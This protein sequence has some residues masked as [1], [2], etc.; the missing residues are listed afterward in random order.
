M[1]FNCEICVF[2]THKKYN[3]QKHLGS[4]RHFIN[5]KRPKLQPK[6]TEITPIV[7]VNP[8]V[9]VA[10]G[11]KCNH[12]DKS[13]RHQSSLSKHVRHS[14]IKNIE[15]NQDEDEDEDLFE[16]MNKTIERKSKYINQLKKELQRL[17]TLLKNKNVHDVS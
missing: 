2:T 16:Q 15:T 14:C 5:E 10:I 4:Q 1:A 12:C 11:F 3:F 13:Y 7:A 6:I 17:N 8:T 9:P